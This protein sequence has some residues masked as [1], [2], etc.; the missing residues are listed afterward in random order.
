[1]NVPKSTPTLLPVAVAIAIGF[2]A[3]PTGAQEKTAVK[4]GTPGNAVP[5]GAWVKKGDTWTT[6]EPVSINGRRMGLV[7]LSPN[8]MMVGNTSAARR[9]GCEDSVN[10]D[11]KV[12]PGS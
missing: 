7:T 3:N 5:C 10:Q 8:A 2:G 6:V 9:S 12:S 4:W 1:M 11:E